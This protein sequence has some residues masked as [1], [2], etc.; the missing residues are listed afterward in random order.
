[1]N[2]GYRV[3]LTDVF[4]VWVC[5]PNKRYSGI[6]LPKADKKRFLDI[7]EEEIANVIPETV[8]TW[9]KPSEAIVRKM[10]IGPTLS[11]P[12]PSGAANGTW[13]TLLSQSPTRA[14][15]LKY[16]ERTVRQH[17]GIPV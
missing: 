15:K 7:L 2:L 17:L 14:N 12:H 16:Y 3:Y 9:G 4:K 6:K 5:N 13:K 8:I 11:V 1:M 10:N